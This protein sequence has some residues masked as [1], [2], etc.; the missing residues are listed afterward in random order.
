M[1]DEPLRPFP[2]AKRDAADSV[3]TRA[4][5]GGTQGQRDTFPRALRA[6]VG[7]P[8]GSVYVPRTPV[9][10]PERAFLDDAGFVYPKQ[11]NG[12]GRRKRDDP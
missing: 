1:A 10:Y 9:L 2:A 8:P 11:H 12:G 6:L 4:E 5:G 3:S 7:W